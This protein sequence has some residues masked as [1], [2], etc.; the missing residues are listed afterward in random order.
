MNSRNPDIQPRKRQLGDSRAL[1]A[2][3]ARLVAGGILS[4]MFYEYFS[5]PET[6]ATLTQSRLWWEI[7]LNL[8]L[9]SAGMVWFSYSD[10]VSP[11]SGKMRILQF[12]RLILAVCAVMTPTFFG[13]FA[14]IFGWFT[15]P[16]HPWVFYTIA[17]LASLHLAGSLF[18]YFRIEGGSSTG[19]S[20][21]S[22]IGAANRS[23][24]YYL[25]FFS[26]SLSFMVAVAVSAF[27]Q[28]KE[29]I[30]LLPLLVFAQG[31]M[32]YIME[33]AGLTVPKRYE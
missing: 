7:V 4:V 11:A 3:L 21:G 16:P 10:R 26:P 33:Y 17:S 20:T 23:V 30:I 27:T 5:R 18:L 1:M 13:V 29:W 12:F 19:S 15:V 14:A 25:V 2:A 22:S 31:S 32:P 8:Q 28:G 6:G 24:G 9:L